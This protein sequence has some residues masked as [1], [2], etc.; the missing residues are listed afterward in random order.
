MVI[1][2]S[3][4][5]KFAFDLLNTLHL[6]VKSVAVIHDVQVGGAKMEP[7]PPA[8]RISTSKNIHIWSIFIT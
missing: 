1:V 6:N 3:N 8:N 2:Y 4:N 7:T 5:M